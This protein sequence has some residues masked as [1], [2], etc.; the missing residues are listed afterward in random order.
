MI[1]IIVE[2]QNYS[3]IIKMTAILPLS[4]IFQYKNNIYSI[5][6]LLEIANPPQIVSVTCFEFL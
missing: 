1:P 5:S 3:D 6:A 2:M 4:F